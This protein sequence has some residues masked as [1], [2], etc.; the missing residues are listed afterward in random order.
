[1]SSVP[2]QAWRQAACAASC[3]KAAGAEQSILQDVGGLRM[4]L[5]NRQTI[6][7]FRAISILY[8]AHYPVC[9]SVTRSRG[10]TRGQRTC[11]GPA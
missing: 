5:M 8:Q 1:M 9:F 2:C 11:L 3:R 10:S 7:I 6:N 4:G